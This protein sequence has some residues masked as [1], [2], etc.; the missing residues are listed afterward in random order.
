M[1]EGSL[2]ERRFPD[3]REAVIYPLTYGRARL[4]IGHPDDDG[5]ADQWEYDTPAAAKTAL[6]TWDGQ[7][8]PSGWFRH[9]GTG[10]RRPGGDPEKEYIRA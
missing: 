9:P 5:F 1:R 8:E 6:A 4:G 10:R 2:A 3:G 7:G